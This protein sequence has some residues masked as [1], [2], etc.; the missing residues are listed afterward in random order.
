MESILCGHIMIRNVCNAHVVPVNSWVPTIFIQNL[1]EEQQ[2]KRTYCTMLWAHLVSI[3][4][5][6]CGPY[7]LSSKH[8]AWPWSSVFRGLHITKYAPTGIYLTQKA[9]AVKILPP[10]LRFALLITAQERGVHVSRHMLHDCFCLLTWNG[11]K[12]KQCTATPHSQPF[13]PIFFYC[14]RPKPVIDWCTDITI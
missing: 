11:V 10:L 13:A 14:S 2:R 9:E 4:G 8:R 5:P 6:M 1:K 7:T 12:A 3:R